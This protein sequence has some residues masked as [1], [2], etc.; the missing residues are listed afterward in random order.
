[1]L[2]RSDLVLFMV[3]PELPGTGDLFI[4]EKLRQLQC[5][6]FLVVNKVDLVTRDALLP[7]ITEFTRLGKFAEVVPVSALTGDNAGRLVELIISCLPP[8]PQYYPAD[9]ITD[10]PERFIVAEIIREKV[11]HLTEQEVPHSVTVVVERMEEQANG[12]VVVDATI[13][14][15]RDSQKGI[16]IGRQGQMLKEIGKLA[17]LEA[18]ALLG[19]K[20]FLEL[21][22]KVKKD[23]R[24]RPAD[25]RNFGY[26]D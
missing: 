8:G 10:K 20:I 18:E 22:V 23:W 21:W 9:M 12:L 3:E 25:I 24:N 13:Y 19:S 5:P 16:L 4:M 17:R 14:V 2:F 1:M 26:A 6:V 15:E 11:L 7:I